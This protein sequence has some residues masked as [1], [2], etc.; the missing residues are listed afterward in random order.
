MPL[1]KN[2]ISFKFF[3]FFCKKMDRIR[4]IRTFATKLRIGRRNRFPS[5]M[6]QDFKPTTRRN[7]ALKLK[8]KNYNLTPAKISTEINHT[9][10]QKEITFENGK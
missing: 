4:F 5:E 1:R 6:V 2:T 9:P 3:I 10:P 7:N 8:N